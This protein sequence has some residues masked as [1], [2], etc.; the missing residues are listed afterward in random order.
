MG[1]LWQLFYSLIVIPFL[2]V[3]LHF[4][5]F[6]NAKV[7]RGVAGRRGLLENLAARTATLPPG[8]RVW[9]HSSSMGEFEQAKPI[10]A[11]LRQTAHDVRTILSYYS[12][13]A[14]QHSLK[15]PHAAIFCYLPLDT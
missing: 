5:A 6:T 15:S 10:I 3:V 9:F 4:L 13:S 14:Y 8:K 11:S 2:W 1:P 12:P 7:R